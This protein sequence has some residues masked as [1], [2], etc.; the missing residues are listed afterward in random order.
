MFAST[1]KAS[2][3]LPLPLPTGTV[4]QFAVLVIVQ[5]QPRGAVT[6]TASLPPSA[7]RVK[8]CVSTVT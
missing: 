1:V 4:I 6:A 7:P 2:R 8:A 5:L 3:A